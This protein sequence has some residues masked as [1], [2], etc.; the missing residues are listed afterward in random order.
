M[1][2]PPLPSPRPLDPLPPPAAEV[3][4]EYVDSGARAIDLSDRP[5]A[6]SLREIMAS[7][8]RM[9]LPPPLPPAGPVFVN[10]HGTLAVLG[11]LHLVLAFVLAGETVWHLVTG[12]WAAL[13][14]DAP[15]RA[16]LLVVNTVGAA[17]TLVLGIGLI[18]ARRW[19][20]ALAWAWWLQGVL[21]M[22]VSAGAINANNSPEFTAKLS[23]FDST[24]AW[25]YLA[26]LAGVAVAFWLLMLL[27]GRRNVRLTCEQAQP[28]PDWTDRRSG[29][30]LLLIWLL[31][32]RAVQ[33]TG[34]ATHHDWPCWGV[35]RSD[36]APWVWGGA[37]LAAAGAAVLVGCGRAAGAW[38]AAG[39]AVAAASS[40]ATTALHQPVETFSA[41]WGDWAFGLRGGLVYTATEAFLILV[42]A[43][44]AMRARRRR[45]VAPAAGSGH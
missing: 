32:D 30:E 16:R 29:A 22:M 14:Q 40:V 21:W 6:D 1:S 4:D 11:L 20:R 39:L 3:T 34:L 25:Q 5:V 13:A 15:E 42:V 37:A 33:W 43:G 17:G 28:Q 18:L 26:G 8:P 10:R 35:W 41:V 9:P 45:R 38:L 27:V 36:Q 44:A 24:P 31:V 2:I 12:G 7:S 23:P 19:A